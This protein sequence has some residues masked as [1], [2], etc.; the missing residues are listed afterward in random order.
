MSGLSV[1]FFKK[2]ALSGRG[3]KNRSQRTGPEPITRPPTVI[4][5][6]SMMVLPSIPCRGMPLTEIVAPVRARERTCDATSGGISASVP[7]FSSTPFVSPF[8][9]KLK[10]S[11][12]LRTVA[13]ALCQPAA[14]P[15]PAGAG[16]GGGGPAISP[17]A[18]PGA[19]GGG[20]GVAA[21]LGGGG[22]GTGPPGPRRALGPRGGGGGATPSSGG[23]G[24]GADAPAPGGGGGATPAGPGTGG[25]GPA[26]VTVI[27]VFV[28]RFVMVAASKSVSPAGP[29]CDQPV[30]VIDV[31]TGAIALT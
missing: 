21:A 28:R 4:V 17:C 14:T 3:H 20:T 9:P 16:G 22:G 11:I 24:G 5:W 19:F 7:F 8:G 29:A 25:G 15:V 10:R 13:E 31:P 12:A 23:G 1:M 6:T 27:A 2:V 18:G 26:G 30:A